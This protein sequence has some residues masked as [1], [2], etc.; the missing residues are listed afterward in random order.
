[1]GEP[2]AIRAGSAPS[3]P[4]SSHHPVDVRGH[5]PHLVAQRDG[6]V[7]FLACDQIQR[8]R[9]DIPRTRVVALGGGNVLVRT[10]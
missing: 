4:S 9:L 10:Q 2:S 6:L 7:A 3:R 8:V 5:G 1:M